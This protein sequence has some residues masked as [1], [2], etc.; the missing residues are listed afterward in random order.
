MTKILIIEDDWDFQ[1]MLVVFLCENG[2]D[3]ESSDN[4]RDGIKKALSRRP[5]LILLDYNL[6]DMNGQEAVFWLESMKRT[7]VIPVLLLS[8]MGASPALA[9]LPGKYQ[10]CKGVLSK[11]QP[12][13]EIL[14]AINSVLGMRTEQARGE[15]L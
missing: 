8:S 2:F 15:T 9:A 12:L 13:H 6:G 14:R 1:S 10:P 11:T 3:V 5:D 4:G 7:R